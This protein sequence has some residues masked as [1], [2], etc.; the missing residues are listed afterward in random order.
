M[1]VTVIIP[2]TGEAELDQAIKSVLNQS[3][4]DTKCYVVCDGDKFRGKVKTITDN[5]LGNPN[6]KVCFLPQNVGANGFYGHRVY[7][8]FTHLIDTKYV[9]YLDQDCYFSNGHVEGCVR[10]IEEGDLDWCYS[11]RTIIDK[12]GHYVCED[13]C[14]S[15]GLWLSYVGSNHIDT[16]CYCIKTEVATRVASAWHGGWGQDRVFLATLGNNFTKT[17]CTK[18]YSVFYRVGGNEGSVTPEFF[19]KGNKIMEQRYNGDFPWQNKI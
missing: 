10:T 12:E 16:N 14:E 15:L 6:F 17:N 18:Y 4:K 3:Y 8:A 11:L 7:A 13:N 1:S 5:Y 2:A 9:M 19:I